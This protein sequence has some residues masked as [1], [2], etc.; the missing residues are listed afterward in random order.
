MGKNVH[1][2]GAP[3]S[4]VG[5]SPGA[6]NFG[7]DAYIGDESVKV[8]V[9]KLAKHENNLMKNV[10]EL[11]K[12]QRF[13]DVTINGTLFYHFRAES[14]FEWIDEYGTVTP[15]GSRQ[16]SFA[17]SFNKSSIGRKKAEAL[18]NEV[19]PTFKLL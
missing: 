15:D 10:L 3:K 4:K 1:T 12:V 16:V 18:I 8:M 13:D 11:D 9:E 19:M 7:S 6:G 17:W 5:I 2:L 14:E